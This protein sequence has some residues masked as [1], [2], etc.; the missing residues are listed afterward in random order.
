MGTG[1]D[2][3]KWAMDVNDRQFIDFSL[4][5]Q[6]D[7]MLENAEENSNACGA[8]AAAATVAVA[9]ALGKTKGILLAHTNSNEVMLRKTGSASRES[10]G[11]AAI[12][13]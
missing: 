3:L 13:F 7:K 4:K 9:K 2:A 11:Y 6:P 5:M 12:V 8:G 10:V 1:K